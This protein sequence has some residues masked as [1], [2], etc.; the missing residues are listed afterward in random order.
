MQRKLLSSYE[1]DMEDT[2][3]YGDADKT[4]YIEQSKNVA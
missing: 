4:L 3:N 2:T 1:I